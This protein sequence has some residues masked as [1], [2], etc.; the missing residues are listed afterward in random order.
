MKMRWLWDTGVIGY[1]K[2]LSYAVFFYNCKIFGFRGGD[3]HRNLDANQ[4]SIRIE[5]GN[6]VLVFEGRNSKNVQ[7]GLH[8]RKVEPK[9]VKQHSMAENPRCVVS[10]FLTYLDNIPKSGPFYR[11]P[12]PPKLTRS[13]VFSSQCVVVNTLSK[14]MK[15]MF[16]EAGIDTEG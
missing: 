4:Y 14:Y 1:A 13:I 9:L 5:N 16:T 7:G 8:Q 3:E 10:L 15:D 2:A 11:K 6:K 12:L